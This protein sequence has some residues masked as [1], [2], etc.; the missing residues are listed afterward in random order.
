MGWKT[1]A[2]GDAVDLK[3]AQAALKAVTDGD[4]G[5]HNGRN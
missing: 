4:S 3:D 1:T 5:A 2:E